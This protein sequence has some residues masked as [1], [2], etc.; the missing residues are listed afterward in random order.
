MAERDAPDLVLTDLMLPQRSG[1]T[2]LDQLKARR[3]RRIPVVLMSGS[4]EPRHRELAA[5]HGAD[6]FILKPFDELE[7]LQVAH[8]LLPQFVRH[9]SR[10]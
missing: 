2:V 7:F 6:A 10:I 9:L 3:I 4:H 1:I 8:E 5:R